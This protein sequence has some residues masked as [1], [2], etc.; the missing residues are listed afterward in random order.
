MRE[1]AKDLKKYKNIDEW[2]DEDGKTRYTKL[3][4]IT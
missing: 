3:N 1:I 2:V 4:I